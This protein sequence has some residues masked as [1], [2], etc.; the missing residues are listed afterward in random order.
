M[1]LNFEI[2]KD[3]ERAWGIKE[4]FCLLLMLGIVVGVIAL[5][6]KMVWVFVC[7]IL[8]LFA[9]IVWSKLTRRNDDG[10][11]GKDT[12]T[13]NECNVLISS[14]DED[15]MIQYNSSTWFEI[16]YSGYRGEIEPSWPF[17]ADIN[18]GNSN[19]ILIHT[20]KNNFRYGFL[21]AE[22]EDADRLLV[23]F[24]QLVPACVNC[25]LTVKGHLTFARVDGRIIKDPKELKRL[26]RHVP[27][28]G[29]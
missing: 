25:K 17:I 28:Q 24:S 22:E 26:W 4:T 5:S 23:F 27:K 6:V 12:I 14:E 3:E 16:V 8:F 7:T 19:I 1:N 20:G 13:F 18:N 9:L 11:L 21:S 2:I 15:A 29:S 10:S